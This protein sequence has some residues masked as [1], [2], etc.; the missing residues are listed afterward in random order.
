MTDTEVTSDEFGSIDLPRRSPTSY[1]GMQR[2]S[3][4]RELEGTESG[5]VRGSE[6]IV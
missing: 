1:P 2:N 4:S 5:M 3:V 6:E